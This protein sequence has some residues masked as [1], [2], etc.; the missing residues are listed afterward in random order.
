MRLARS[1]ASRW[2]WQRLSAKMPIFAPSVLG[3]TNSGRRCRPANRPAR[4]F[5]RLPPSVASAGPRD[6]RRRRAQDWRTCPG[7]GGPPVAGLPKRAKPSSRASAGDRTSRDRTAPRRS[8]PIP[9]VSSRH[10][11]SSLKR[12]GSS[13]SGTNRAS[14]PSG[15]ERFGDLAGELRQIGRLGEI[16]RDLPGDIGRVAESFQPGLGLGLGL[17]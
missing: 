10:G 14:I 15:A 1:T 11:A 17:R 5:P 2:V 3:L 13:P 6:R 4:R 12:E 7:R 9:C 8:A 16:D